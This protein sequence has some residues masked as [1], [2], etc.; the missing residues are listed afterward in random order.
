M[1]GASEVYLGLVHG[2]V[3]NVFALLKGFDYLTDQQKNLLI[4]RT[5]D[6]ILKTAISDEHFANWLPCV[7]NPWPGAQDPM[8]QLCHG[9]PATIIGVA[10]LWPYVDEQFNELLLKAGELIWHAGPLKKP[11]GLCH[12]T[13]G[14]GYAFL[15]LYKAT[16]NQLWL[17]RA[18]QF[19]MHAI[20]QYQ[21]MKTQYGEIRT[22]SWCGDLGLALYLQ[23]CIDEC[24]QFPML[25][26]F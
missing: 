19:A 7:G 13:A 1:Y 11:W 17:D 15:K 6:T 18:R 5:Q 12:G 14:N 23:D 4:E 24:D 21:S 26:Y 10:D 16:G 9:A 25:D 20:E 8:L 2:F 3:G 22:D